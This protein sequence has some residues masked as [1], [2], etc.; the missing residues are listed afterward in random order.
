MNMTTNGWIPT[1]DIKAVF[2]L[3][4]QLV[5]PQLRRDYQQKKASRLATIERRNVL[6]LS[7]EIMLLLS[8]HQIATA[9]LLE[10]INSRVGEDKE[11]FLTDA[12]ASQTISL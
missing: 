9:D 5:V 12:A 7:E 2:S 1:E 6:L 11:D 10:W 8:E 4:Q 3:C